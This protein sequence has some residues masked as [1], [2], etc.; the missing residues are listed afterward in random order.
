[1]SIETILEQPTIKKRHLLLSE[2]LN[3]TYKGELNEKDTIYFRQIFSKYYTPDDE[4]IKFDATTISNV[5][6]SLDKWGNNYFSICVENKWYPTSIKRLAG[7]N[8]T[9]SANLKRALRNAI[10]PQIVK[11]RM[12]NPLDPNALCPI[13]K[14]K[15]CN[16]AQVDHEI[17]FHILVKEWLQ[18]NSIPPLKYDFDKTNYILEES[19]SIDWQNYHSKYAKLRWVSKEGNKS[20]HLYYSK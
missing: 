13:T 17:P 5:S 6:I 10:E 9:D 20:A 11:Y 2:Y 1:M 8:R 3:K 12:E 4:D 14:S 15:L 7:S 19:F 18:N 16:N